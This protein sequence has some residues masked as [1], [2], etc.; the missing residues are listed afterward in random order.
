MVTSAAWEDV[1]LPRTTRLCRELDSQLTKHLLVAPES[2]LL[3]TP[4][5]RFNRVERQHRKQMELE[6]T[7]N[8][9]LR[10]REASRSRALSEWHSRVDSRGYGSHFGGVR[11]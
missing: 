6:A 11:A 4:H 5:D 9:K 7:R 2:K 1:T 8:D 10:E 3:E